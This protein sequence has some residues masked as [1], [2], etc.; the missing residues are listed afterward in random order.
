MRSVV[1]ARKLDGEEKANM[2]RVRPA[3][4]IRVDPASPHYDDQ[5]KFWVD[6]QYLPLYSYPSPGEFRPSQIESQLILEP[7]G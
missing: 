4:Q 7:E 2:A 6:G 1:S 3:S 5:P